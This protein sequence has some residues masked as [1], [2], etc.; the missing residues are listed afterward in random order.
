MKHDPY[1]PS[2][3]PMLVKCPA[4]SSTPGDTV[5]TEKGSEKH[6]YVEMFLDPKSEY[7]NNSTDELFELLGESNEGREGEYKFD[8]NDIADVVT[9]IDQAREF[10]SHMKN[11]CSNE[12]EVITEQWVNLNMLGISGG[13][14]DLVLAC[15]RTIVLIDF[16]FGMLPV[17]PQSEQLLS[18]MVGLNPFNDY[19]K[20]Y[21]VIIQPKV[22]DEA[23]V[24]EVTHTHLNYHKRMMSEVIEMAKLDNPP[25]L[26]HDKCNYCSKHM[27]CPA[28]IGSL[29]KSNQ[30]VTQNKEI[31]IYN[32]PNESL[33][34]MIDQY[35]K[36]KAFGGALKQELFVRLNK[37]EESSS[38][39]LGAG[40]R[41][42]IWR[43]EPAAFERLKEIC[44]EQGI[45][46]TELYDSKLISVAKAEKL[47]AKSKKDVAELVAFVDG[48]VSLKRKSNK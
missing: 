25:Y 21:T 38:Y 16:K 19:D 7:Y 17:S 22:Y 6:H 1:G 30:M 48:K 18:Y 4:Y 23:Q 2:T 27:R 44:K 41:K 43:N 35:D 26:Q 33:E 31:K 8:N 28:T 24:F 39:E 15:D 5:H 34:R 29:E 46:P 45:S 20:M 10:I 11:K 12:L 47:L 40:R 14:P 36:I 37:G 3:H 13:T 32:I 9:A 42:R